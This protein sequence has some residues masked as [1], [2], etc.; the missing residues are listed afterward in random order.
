M[1]EL[2]VLVCLLSNPTECSEK[3]VPEATADDVVTCIRAAGDKADAWQ[4]V[5]HQY[6]VIGWRCEKKGTSAAT[7]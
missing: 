2:V 3:G 7:R 6:F 4:K 1:A 5:N